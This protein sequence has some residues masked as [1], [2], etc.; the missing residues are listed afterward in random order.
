MDEFVMVVD[1][2]DAAAGP[3]A[4]IMARSVRAGVVGWA[5]I[6]VNVIGNGP[7]RHMQAVGQLKFGGTVLGLADQQQMAAQFFS[8]DESR[9]HRHGEIT[10]PEGGVS[11]FAGR[12]EG[13]AAGVGER[14][15]AASV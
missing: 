3:G 13:E 7:S 12:D 10:D 2:R 15:T 1:W 6:V 4:L 9:I 14:P 5:V 8:R 11:V